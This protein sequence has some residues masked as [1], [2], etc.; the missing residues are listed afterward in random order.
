[1]SN[2]IIDNYDEQEFFNKDSHTNFIKKNN[3]DV[4]DSEMYTNNDLHKIDIY[5]SDDTRQTS[6]IMTLAEY[7]RVVSER[8]KQIENGSPIF[9]QDIG[10]ESNP[11]IIAEMEIVQKKCPMLITRYL[12]ANIVEI[13]KVNE[14]IIPFK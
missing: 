2:E 13:Y 6:E 3:I 12:S 11:I 7:T 10:D 4:L 9:I 14:M 5:G 1:M 8:A